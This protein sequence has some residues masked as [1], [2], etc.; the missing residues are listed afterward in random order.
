MA[1]KLFYE[2]GYRYLCLPWD[3][4][5]REELVQQVTTG[6]LT[7]CRAI[8]PGS[9]SASNVIFLA[10]YGFEVTGVDFTISANDRSLQTA[11]DAGVNARYIVDDLTNLQSVSGVG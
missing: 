10:Q 6:Q 8:D 11:K 5:P 3:M 9:G 4:G 1:F 7:P 2:I